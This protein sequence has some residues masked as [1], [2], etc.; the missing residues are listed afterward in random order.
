MQTSN[1]MFVKS[2]IALQK[3]YMANELK[4]TDI[5][6]YDKRKKLN[7]NDFETT[8]KYGIPIVRKQNI[9]PDTIELLSYTKT[10]QND[11]ENL[12]K[13]IHFFTYDWLFDSAYDNPEK[14][15]EKLKQYYAVLTPDFS[16]YTDMSL[17]LQIHSIFKSRWCGAFWQS[18]GMKVIPT[19]EWGDERSFDFCFDGIEQGSVVAVAT[20]G[21]KN[22]SGFLKG[23]SKMLE[24]IKPALIICYGEPFSGMNGN[25]K[26]ISPYNH[27]ELIGK[28]GLEEYAKR[29]FK[30]DLYP[31]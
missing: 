11:C 22:E 21:R 3:Q 6:K 5:K 16:T 10:K 23:Y 8:G 26:F 25:V 7:R 1:D 14:V 2:F 15:S 31:S 28:L 29:Y 24:V 18:L 30:G 27:N 4:T 12:H 19:I 17:A 9:D 20:Y 13:T